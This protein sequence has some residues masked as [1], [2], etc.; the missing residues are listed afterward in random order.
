MMK[1]LLLPPRESLRT[2]V[3]FE[4]RKGMCTLC[5]SPLRLLITMPKVVRDLLM[6][7]ASF[8]RSP[9]QAVDFCRSEPAKSTKCSLLLLRLAQ[10][11]NTCLLWM[12]RVNTAWLR[13]LYRFIWVYPM[14]RLRIP[15]FSRL[16][17]ISTSAT[18]SSARFSTNTPFFI[19]SRT[20][21]FLLDWSRRST[22]CS[23]YI[24]K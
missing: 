17:A 10:P 5:F 22:S 19:S 3:S 9:M 20:V 2:K 1:V 15:W 21:N 7:L 6:L 12:L 24:S 4:S 18:G 14:W 11:F 16:T 13:L 8:S 23:L